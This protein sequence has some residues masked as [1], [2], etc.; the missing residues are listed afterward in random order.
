[1]YVATRELELSTRKA[2]P[3]D[4]V[5][6]ALHWTYPVLL[7]HLNMGWI[8]YIGDGADKHPDDL[9]SPATL[10]EK[11]KS[12]GAAKKAAPVKKGSEKKEPVKAKAPVTKKTVSKVEKKTSVTTAHNK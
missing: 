12:T 7:A 4:E 3:G 6:E 9:Q 11:P 1:M 8:K 5:P 10:I 2:K